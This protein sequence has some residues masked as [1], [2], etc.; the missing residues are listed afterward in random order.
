MALAGLLAILLAGSSVLAGGQQSVKL[1]KQAGAADVS[2]VVVQEP[3]QEGEKKPLGPVEVIPFAMALGPG[4]ASTMFHAGELEYRFGDKAVKGAPFSAQL[5]IETT[6]TLSNGVHISHKVTGAM[7]RDSDGRTRREQAM[8]GVAV[9]V[10]TITDPVAGVVYSLNTS[11]HTASKITFNVSGGGP[12]TYFIHAET[13]H[14]GP[15][16]RP[17]T[18]T[19]EHG[20]NVMIAPGMPGM[21]AMAAAKIAAAGLDLQPKTESLG[22][23]MVE[24]VNAEGTRSTITIPAGSQGNDAS[25]DIVSEKWYSPDL[26]IVVMSSHSDPRMGESVYK[27]TNITRA[28]SAHSLFEVPA[29]FTVNEAKGGFRM[30]LAKPRDN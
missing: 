6:Q 11:E 19:T 26:Q 1:S 7:Y 25:F 17:V 22:S 16:G 13:R 29:D 28:E 12:D 3:G 2:F 18:A 30:P 8:D 27:L 21:G 20:A 23:R 9:G 15:G 5:S 24:G 14:A 4:Q 10:V